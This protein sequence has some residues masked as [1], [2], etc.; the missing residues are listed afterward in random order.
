MMAKKKYKIEEG[1]DP[2]TKKDLVAN[3]IHFYTMEND[4]NSMLKGVKLFKDGIQILNS[5]YDNIYVITVTRSGSGK[6]TSWEKSSSDFIVCNKHRHEDEIYSVRND[7]L[8]RVNEDDGTLVNSNCLRRSDCYVFSNRIDEMNIL[9]PDGFMFKEYIDGLGVNALPSGNKN[10]KIKDNTNFLKAGLIPVERK[11]KLNIFEDYS[12]LPVLNEFADDIVIKKNPFN[13]MHPIIAVKYEE[14]RCDIISVSDL[15]PIFD[16]KLENIL[17]NDDSYTFF[18]IGGTQ[19][20]FV[21]KDTYIKCKDCI[22]CE[23]GELIVLENGYMFF[24]N[25]RLSNLFEKVYDIDSL[26]P[27][28]MKNGKYNFLERTTGKPVF[29]NE[30]FD[31]VDPYND[32]EEFGS[33]NGK[34]HEFSVYIDGENEIRKYS[35]RPNF[36]IA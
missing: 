15:K 8:Y 30:W 3:G 21:S 9:T 33:Y 4:K 19:Y 16:G 17:T 10:T 18:V 32:E 1:F 7:S 12:L 20:L 11:G 31:D 14:G 35:P 13:S 28:V 6:L 23:Y 25:G 26:F 29:D 5:T 2:S 34:T 22:K 27:I 36:S 24:F